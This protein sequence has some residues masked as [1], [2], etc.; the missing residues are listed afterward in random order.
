M[1][2]LPKEYVPLK[3]DGYFWNITDCQLY[4]VKVTGMLKPLK[5]SRLWQDGMH[6]S[7]VIGYNISVAGRKRFV[8]VSDLVKLTPADTVFPG[9][10]N[11]INK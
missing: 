6:V 11:S 5:K 10:I 1:V 2:T 9:W 7:N 3:Y 8:S 4:S